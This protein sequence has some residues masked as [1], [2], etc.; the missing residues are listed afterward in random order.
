MKFCSHCVLD[1]VASSYVDPGPDINIKLSSYFSQ[2]M[3]PQ[4]NVKRNEICLHCVIST[5]KLISNDQLSHNMKTE[6][7]REETI[8]KKTF[9]IEHKMTHKHPSYNWLQ[10]ISSST[11]GLNFVSLST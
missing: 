3:L 2:P 11:Q 4:G 7:T 6:K 10:G 8:S 9:S 5:H 1:D